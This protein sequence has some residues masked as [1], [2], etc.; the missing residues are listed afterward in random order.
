MPVE[1]RSVAPQLVLSG[2]IDVAV[3]ADLRAA[4]TR[5][6][7]EVEP[8]ARLD[9]DMTAVTFIDSSG[10]GA[11]VSIR[12]V[13]DLGNHRVALLIDAPSIVRLF[14]LMG[15]RD[16]FTILSSSHWRADTEVRNNQHG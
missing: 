5:A 11:L 3:A 7:D 14:E 4:G 12:K 15:L 13:A 9:I 10:F 16:S 8:G 2:E 1:E 6:L